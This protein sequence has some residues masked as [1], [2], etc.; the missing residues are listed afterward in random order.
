MVNLTNR[1]DPFDEMED[2]EEY[3]ER[4]EMFLTVQ[5]VPRDKKVAHIISDIGSKV[6][7]VLKNL[8]M[9]V[10]PK[11]STLLKIRKALF[12]PKPPVIG[13]RFVFHQRVQ[14]PGDSFSNG[15]MTT[16]SYMRF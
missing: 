15:T 8:L 6:C 10:A 16:G 5:G 1:F 2:I 11:D 13:Q 4:L 7:A 3:F 14:M 9:P 12:K